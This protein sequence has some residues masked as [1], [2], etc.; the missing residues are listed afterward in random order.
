MPVGCGTALQVGVLQRDTVLFDP[1]LP[2]W[3]KEAIDALG[4][5]SEAKVCSHSQ[6]G[7]GP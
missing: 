3:K 6:Q 4:M 7:A 5:G 2:Q 1:E